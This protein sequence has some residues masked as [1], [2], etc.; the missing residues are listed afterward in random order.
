MARRLRHGG[1]QHRRIVAGKL[2]SVANPGLGASLVNVVGAMDVGKEDRIE[3]SGFQRA[4]EVDPES[5]RSIV[6]RRAVARVAELPE[7]LQ[8]RRALAE[9]VEMDNLI[10]KGTVRKTSEFKENI[11]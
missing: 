7:R 4:R 3:A 1:K 10:H 9:S 11:P 2:H 6:L 5:G 8:R